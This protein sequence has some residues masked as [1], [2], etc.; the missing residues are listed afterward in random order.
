MVFLNLHHGILGCG[1]IYTK[2]TSKFSLHGSAILPTAPSLTAVAEQK[3]KWNEIVYF[4][5]TVAKS[6][7]KKRYYIP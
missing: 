2:N 1:S 6:F 3:N 5:F 7:L 4:D